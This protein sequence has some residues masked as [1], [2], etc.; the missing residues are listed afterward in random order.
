MKKFNVLFLLAMIVS[1]AIFTT[2]CTQRLVDFTV[3]S[4]KNVGMKAEGK[5]VEVK[6]YKFFGINANIKSVID[7]ALESAGPDYDLLVDGVLSVSNFTFV[8]GYKVKGKAVKS[9]DIKLAMGE[10]EYN[11]W[12]A[13]NVSYDANKPETANNIEVITE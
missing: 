12:Y 7:K 13:E 3:I 9:G 2:S 4:T 10:E 6:D 5:M 8:A 11:K 1:S